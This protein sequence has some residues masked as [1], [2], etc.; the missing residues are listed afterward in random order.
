MSVLGATQPSNPM[1][2][3]STIAIKSVSDGLLLLFP[4]NA[5]LVTLPGW[6]G[7]AAADLIY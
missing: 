1:K 5:D 2:P 3:N 4:S 7:R 6:G